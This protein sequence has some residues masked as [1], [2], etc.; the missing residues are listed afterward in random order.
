MLSFVNKLIH[1]TILQL[2]FSN[3]VESYRLIIIKLLIKIIFHRPIIGDITFPMQHLFLN[4][5]AGGLPEC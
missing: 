3:A 4:A 1:Y 2:L 5:P